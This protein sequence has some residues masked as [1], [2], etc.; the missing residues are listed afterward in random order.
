[1]PLG[2]LKERVLLTLLGA[3][4]LPQGGVL[5]CGGYEGEEGGLL[6]QA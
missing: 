3:L 6:S 4:V 5:L 2:G 1:M